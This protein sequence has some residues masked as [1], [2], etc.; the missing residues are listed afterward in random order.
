[1]VEGT[2]RRFCNFDSKFIRKGPQQSTLIETK[3]ELERISAALR[4]KSE[5]SGDERGKREKAMRERR[6]MGFAI[7]GGQHEC[8][9]L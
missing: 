3:P 8:G 2:V 1:M 6:G 9:N 5:G 7:G 4:T